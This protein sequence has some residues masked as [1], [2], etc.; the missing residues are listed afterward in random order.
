MGIAVVNRKWEC[1]DYT[2]GSDRKGIL[3]VVKIVPTAL[4]D[5]QRSRNINSLLISQKLHDQCSA[6][7]YPD[8]HQ[9]TFPVGT[10]NLITSTTSFLTLFI[11]LTYIRIYTIVGNKRSTTLQS[12]LST[13]L[14]CLK[15]TSNNP[16][17]L[18]HHPHSIVFYIAWITN[19]S[20][21]STP[22]HS[23]CMIHGIF[24]NTV[25]EDIDTI[26]Q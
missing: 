25:Q 22:L 21:H 3:V 15:I 24:Y 16:P 12:L 9:N 1:S 8:N 10:C 18:L 19:K 11:T 2:T 13:Q 6:W 7:H 20:I 5:Y 17:L 26:A 23:T 14:H 4:I